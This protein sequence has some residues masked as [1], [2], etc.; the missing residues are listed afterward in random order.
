MAA[1]T[2]IGT[3]FT[4]IAAETFVQGAPTLT[5]LAPPR[6][7]FRMCLA[8]EALAQGDMC[9]VLP[10]DGLAYKTPAG[11][12]VGFAGMA[13]RKVAAGQ[14][15]TLVYDVSIYYL[16]TA[17]AVGTK[18]Y[19]SPGTAGGIDQTPNLAGVNEVDRITKSGTVSGGTFTVTFRGQTT[20]AL[21][22]DISNA[23]LQTAL[24][25][26]ST[27]GASNVTVSGGPV[28]SAFVALTFSDGLGKTDLPIIST[29]SGSLTGGG[30]YDAS[31]ATAGVDPVGTWVATV[32]N[33][34]GN[35]GAT[36]KYIWVRGEALF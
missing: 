21:A 5:T 30:T 32:V 36:S 19:L 9:Y 35:S 10:G 27:I 24:R 17:L 28:N 13:T 14:A 20:S 29:D 25:A 33:T 15:I 8:G 26:L 18:L 22:Y 1:E 31:T 7:C 12:P 6:N 3:S 34:P 11:H 4:P 23:N 16:S 2:R